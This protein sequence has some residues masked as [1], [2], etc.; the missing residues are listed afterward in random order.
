MMENLTEPGFPRY[1][2]RPNQLGNRSIRKARDRSAWKVYLISTSV[3]Q[4]SERRVV[5]GRL[6]SVQPYLARRMLRAFENIIL[7]FR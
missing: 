2:D 1:W 4:R 5:D 6:H 7:V 3:Q